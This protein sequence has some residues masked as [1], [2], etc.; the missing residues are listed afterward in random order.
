MGIHIQR[1]DLVAQRRAPE[2]RD[3]VYTGQIF[4]D[5]NTPI[6]VYVGVVETDDKGKIKNKQWKKLLTD[7]PE[8]INWGITINNDVERPI[9]PN[10]KS[11]INFSPNDTQYFDIY[12]DGENSIMLEVDMHQLEL[13]VL[14]CANK[15]EEVLDVIQNKWI[16]STEDDIDKI[17]NSIANMSLP[18]GLG[19]GASSS[20]VPMDS[21]DINIAFRNVFGSE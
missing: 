9:R 1:E 3:L 21:N 4:V 12:Q 10:N 8:N 16:S 7:D 13:A 19:S 14:E 18:N 5:L 15:T 11:I 17:M 20:V 2:L 6:T